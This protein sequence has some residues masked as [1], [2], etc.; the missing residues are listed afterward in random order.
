MYC[1][2]MVC[3]IGKLSKEASRIACFALLLPCDTFIM[4]L[5]AAVWLQFATKIIAMHRLHVYQSS[6]IYRYDLV[7]L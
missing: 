1:G 6:A 3:L 4:S 2:K 5:S 7:R